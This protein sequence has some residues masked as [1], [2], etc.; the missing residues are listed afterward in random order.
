MDRNWG[1]ITSGGMFQSL[2][3][4]LVG[5]E[6]PKAT[7]F[8]RP[9]PDGA[10]DAR[11]GDGTR[12]FQMKYHQNASAAKA[13]QDA[14]DEAKTIK[15]YRVPGHS[16]YS[17]WLGVKHWCLVTNVAF[18]PTDQQRWDNEVVPL[19][20]GQ[21]FEEVDRWSRERLDALLDKHPEVDRAYFGGEIRAFLSVPEMRERVRAQEPFLQRID[22]GEIFGRADEVDKARTFLKSSDNQFLV[23]QGPGGIG[24]TRLLLEIGEAIASEGSWYVLWANVATMTAT[25]TWFSGIVRERPTLL[26]VDEPDDDELLR[27]LLEQIG[28]SASK[29]KVVVTVRSSNDLVHR[30]LDGDRI[31]RRVQKLEIKAL[32]DSDAVAMCESLLATGRLASRPEEERKRAAQDLSKRFARHPVWLTLAVQQLE[33]RGD[34]TQIPVSANDLADRYL[35]EIEKNQDG[36]A[37]ELVRGLLRWVA[38]LRTVNRENSES[39]EQIAKESGVGSNTKLLEHLHSLVK[40]RVLV[41]RGARDRLFELKPDVLRDHV[42]LRWLSTEVGGVPPVIASDEA[43]RLIDSIRDPLEKGSLDRLGRSKLE[44]LSRTEFLLGL[45]G[46]KVDILA[47]LFDA[48]RSAVPSMSA[49]QRVALAE[50]LG[51][52][53]FFQPLQVVSMIRAIRSSH[54]EDERIEGLF[55]DRVVRHADVILSLAWPLA[56]AAMGAREDDVKVEV[57]RELCSVVGAEVELVETTLKYG[58]P[59][60][61]KRAATLV[62]RVLQGGPNYWGDFDA[63]GKKLSLEILDA[64]A[65][66]APTAA[67]TALLKALVQPLLAIERSQTWSDDRS[68]YVRKIHID[69]NQPAWSIRQQLLERLKQ[70]LV[71]NA[72][73]IESR[74]ALWSAFAQA[75]RELN[76]ASRYMEEREDGTYSAKLREDRTYSTELQENLEWT[77]RVLEQRNASFEELGQ[78]REVWDW[79]RRFEDDPAL[80]AASLKL[81]ELYVSDQLATEFEDLVGHDSW[82]RS[83]PRE[84]AKTKAAELASSTESINEFV[85]RGARFFK[86]DPR[87]FPQ[88]FEIARQIGSLAPECEAIRKFVVAAL[89]GGPSEGRRLE[90]AIVVADEWVFQVRESATS[91]DPAALVERLLAACANDSVRVQLLMKVYGRVSRPRVIKDFTPEE[92]ALFRRQGALFAAQGHTNEY[93]AALATTLKHDWVTARTM[94]EDLVRRRSV[95]ERSG[96]LHSLLNAVFRVVH[97]SEDKDL[98]EGLGEWLLNQLVLL[99]DFDNIVGDDEWHL[100]EILK[101]VGRP[102][103]QWLSAVLAKRRELEATRAKDDYS[104]AISHHVRISRYVQ[105]IAAADVGQLTVTQAIE[106]MLGFIDDN[107]TVDYYLPEVLHD[108]DPEGL[109][110]PGLVVGLIGH[111][112]DLERVRLLARIASEYV[113]GTAAW[114]DIAK[115]ALRSRHVQSKDHELSMFHALGAGGVTSWSYTPGEVPPVFIAEVQSAKSS[116]AAATDECLQRYWRWRVGNAEV[117]LR[118]QEQEA[119]DNRDE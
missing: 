118:E 48:I 72:T 26:L 21:G 79:H 99:P 53:A 60:D 86:N 111:A 39:I 97:E 116:L 16:R 82:Q 81:E 96:A 66:R 17:Q 91:E 87:K 83:E 89:A 98:P 106:A 31:K 20:R 74:C 101:R 64:I 107:G 32:R 18:N 100:N 59:N 38:L 50:V 7:L 33:E 103:V 14:T 45:G 49:S 34:L 113:A 85:D 41:R 42:L 80:K 112:G 25:S 2:G 77:R 65:A 35:R 56:H 3:S 58:L 8:A 71:A 95:E 4:T 67:E 109:V 93:I 76:M 13:I 115:V 92:H 94:L 43:K 70:I 62:T 84:K 52:V 69:P 24:K 28:G 30:F 119:K 117:A 19:F 63:A 108:V 73:P 11:S 27:V 9:G 29:W 54:A 12:V 22:V 61:G 36:V 114:D 47:P 5:F 75:H 90:F 104:R 102:S 105:R 23:I 15:K 68:L 44:S 88:L 37:P 46:H 6:D 1:D 40:R 55:G 110:V 78:A 57:L 51:S 10:Q